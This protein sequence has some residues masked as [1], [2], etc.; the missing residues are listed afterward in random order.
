MNNQIMNNNKCNKCRKCLKL[1]SN[2]CFNKLF[3]KN[4]M[5]IDES[6]SFSRK[7]KKLLIDMTLEQRK[8]V[9]NSFGEI[10]NYNSDFNE[11]AMN[12]LLDFSKTPIYENLFQLIKSQYS[13]YYYKAIIIAVIKSLLILIQWITILI[14]FYPKYECIDSPIKIKFSILILKLIY[15][16]FFDF[17]YIIN[18][19]YFFKQFERIKLKKNLV[20]FYQIIGYIYNG[21]IYILIFFS[22]K[23]CANAREDNV[24]FIKDKYL[25]IICGKIFY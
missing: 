25:K 24:F 10:L 16:L 15:F 3:D 5:A 11:I 23:N 8:I 18:E 7:N 6:Q 13:Y 19:F 4:I 21:I 2:D 12:Y 17:V 14:T 9:I 1:F 20:V 22:N